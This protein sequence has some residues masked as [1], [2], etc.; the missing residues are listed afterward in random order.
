MK[1]PP[2]SRLSSDL[3]FADDYIYS[4]DNKIDDSGPTFDDRLHVTLVRVNV[5]EGYEKLCRGKRALSS[6][7]VCLVAHQK[8]MEHL[9]HHDWVQSDQ[10]RQCCYYVFLFETREP[11]KE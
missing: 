9:L 4:L 6:T 7:A 2:R 5:V 10:L 1:Q 3:I 8:S 11:S